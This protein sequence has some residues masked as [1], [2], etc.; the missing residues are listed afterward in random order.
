MHDIWNPWH[1]CVKCSGG[2]ENCYMYYIDAMRDKDGAEIYLT[3][4]A[5]SPLP[6]D[7]KGQYKIQSGKMISVCMTSDF[8]LGK[9]VK[10][11]P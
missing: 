3:S 5:R 6:R 1:G 11:A 4:N 7:R 10:S 8:F 9:T 2:C